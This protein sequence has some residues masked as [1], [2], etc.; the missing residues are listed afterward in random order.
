MSKLS[1]KFVEN[2]LTKGRDH[3]DAGLILFV[4]RTLRRVTKSWVFRFTSPNTWLRRDMGLG[5]FDAVGLAHALQLA[6]RAGS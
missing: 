5:S 6:S 2:V 1:A 3:N 4:N